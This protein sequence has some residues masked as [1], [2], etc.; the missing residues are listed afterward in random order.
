MPMQKPLFIAFFLISSLLLVPRIVAVEEATSPANI[1]EVTEN[2]RERLQTTIGGDDTSS[3][4]RLYGYVG[5]VKDIIKNTIVI[6]EKDGKKNIMIGEGAVITRTPGNATIKIDNIRIDDYVIAIGTLAG[7]E[8]TGKKLIVSSSSFAPPEKISG[9]GNVE[10]IAKSSIAVKTDAGSTIL[11]LDSKTVIKSQSSVIEL[12]DLSIGD[13]VV[14]AAD[15]DKSDNTATV[16]MR[17]K[18]SN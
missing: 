17:V 3:Q 15:V 12:S 1:N 11:D 2:I 5:V 7:E 9:I 16:I 13:R 10:K 8:L 6:E 18:S 4:E 14:Y